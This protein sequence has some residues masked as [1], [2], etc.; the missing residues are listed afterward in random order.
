MTERGKVR[1]F[2]TVELA[3]SL[4]N[5]QS[6]LLQSVNEVFFRNIIPEAYFI[7]DIIQSPFGYTLMCRDGNSMLT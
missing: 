5:G 2:L 1:T 4:A 7:K 3:V 6:F